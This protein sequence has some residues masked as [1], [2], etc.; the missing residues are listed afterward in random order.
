MIF[1]F[2]KKKF[3]RGQ[4]IFQRPIFK[5]GHMTTFFSHAVQ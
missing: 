1:Q 3:P 2:A 4:Q 5:Y